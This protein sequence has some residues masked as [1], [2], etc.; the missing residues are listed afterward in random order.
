MPQTAP[1]RPFSRVLARLPSVS[2]DCRELA[3]LRLL[4]DWDNLPKT[5]QQLIDEI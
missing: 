2:P 5:P 4:I 3:S 1:K